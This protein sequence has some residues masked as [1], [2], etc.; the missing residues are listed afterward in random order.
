M[1]VF[2]FQLLKYNL[3]VVMKNNVQHRR[4]NVEINGDEMIGKNK[5]DKKL[6][7]IKCLQYS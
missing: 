4:R 7:Q 3:I 5:K 2:L 1:F 6:I